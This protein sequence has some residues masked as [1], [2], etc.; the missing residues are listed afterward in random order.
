MTRQTILIFTLVL[1]TLAPA[2][3]RIER[4]PDSLTF[5]L[6][7]SGFVP[8]VPLRDTVVRNR[9]LLND[10]IPTEFVR[11]FGRLWRF[12]RESSSRIKELPGESGQRITI[13]SDSVTVGRYNRVKRY[14][15]VVHD[16]SEGSPFTL[17]P[18]SHLYDVREQLAGIRSIIT[19]MD[20]DSTAEKTIYDEVAQQDNAPIFHGN[21]SL[22]FY[23]WKNNRPESW[24]VT[25]RR[26]YTANE[27]SR[28]AVFYTVRD[29]AGTLRAV[30]SPLYGRNGVYRFW[31]EDGKTLKYRFSRGD[32]YFE[33]MMS[34]LG[35]GKSS[36]LGWGG[37][38]GLVFPIVHRIEIGDNGRVRSPIFPQAIYSY[39]S[40]GEA[41]LSFETGVGFYN[42]RDVINGTLFGVGVQV[43]GGWKSGI[44]DLERGDL[45]C[46]LGG[47]I[48]FPAVAM[49]RGN[50]LAEV[51]GEDRGD[52]TYGV[53]VDVNLLWPIVGVGALFAALFYW[54]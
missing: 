49:V 41:G 10:T 23:H 5:T 22:Y 54:F 42:G 17:T 33:E 32:I 47:V 44:T 37:T 7:D 8:A 38:A 25:K 24:E 19:V 43:L 30:A 40:G 46:G 20:W 21:N 14:R 1:F 35:M 48:S 34:F 11:L 52:I 29:S 53:S 16:N 50:V 13:V 51:V 15:G 9:H 6:K 12:D 27:Y 36:Q 28:R 26:V 31:D 18:Y 2:F 4:E 3:A 39:L 45:H